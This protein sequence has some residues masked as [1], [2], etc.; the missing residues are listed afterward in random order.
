ME[1]AAVI[2]HPFQWA[3]FRLDS[4]AHQPPPLPRATGALPAIRPIAL[5]D[6]RLAL[7]A[8][9]RD[10]L[11]VRSDVIFL[12]VVYPL[13][14]LALWRFAIGANMLHMLFPLLAGFALLGPLFATGLY[15]M[16]RQ[17]EQGREVTWLTAFDAFRSPGIGAILGLGLILLALFAVWLMAAEMIYRV[18]LGPAHLA[19]FGAFAHGVLLTGTGQAMVL[20]GCAVG[21]VFAMVA[22]SLS[23]ISFPL[24]LDRQVTLAEAIGA[25]LTAVRTSPR[26]MAVWGLTVTGLLVVGAAPFLVGLA[27]VLPILGHATWHLYRRILPA[28][29]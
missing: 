12:C 28:S 22:F 21:F 9:T 26:E 29:P 1:K 13:A 3:A 25:S 4:V 19:T 8:G 6:V 27:L 5:A 7:A 14:G 2:R 17:R 24:L 16:S 23:A 11:A 10:F 20:L 15:E 18:T